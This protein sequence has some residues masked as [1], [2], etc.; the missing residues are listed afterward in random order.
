MRYFIGA[1]R[2][3]KEYSF[4]DKKDSYFL[5]SSAILSINPHK[6]VGQYLNK[7]NESY[8]KT[9]ISLPKK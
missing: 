8:L 4:H 7:D 1:D 3:G 2:A 9:E 6:L 5:G